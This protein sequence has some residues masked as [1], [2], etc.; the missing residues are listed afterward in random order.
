MKTWRFKIRKNVRN[1]VIV[2]CFNLC[3]FAFRDPFLAKAARKR[4]AD[5]KRRKGLHVWRNVICQDWVYLWEHW[6]L[7]EQRVPAYGVSTKNIYR[8]RRRQIRNCCV[9]L[10]RFLPSTFS[11]RD[12]LS[13]KAFERELISRTPMRGVANS[14][15]ILRLLRH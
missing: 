3:S 4:G 12:F 1:M 7:G 8:P 13:D 2:M 14:F 5:L 15:K 6:I 11:Y 9:F 10:K